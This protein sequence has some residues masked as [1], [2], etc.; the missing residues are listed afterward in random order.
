MQIVGQDWLLDH[1]RV[2]LGMWMEN[3]VMLVLII[4][5]VL[6]WMIKEMCMLLTLQ[7]LPS[8]R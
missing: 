4:Q 8:E 2:T 3:P 7:I 5:K 1:F 6:L